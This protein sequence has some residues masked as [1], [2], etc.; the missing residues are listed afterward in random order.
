MRFNNICIIQKRKCAWKEILGIYIFEISD[1]LF[2]DHAIGSWVR[3]PHQGSSSCIFCTVLHIAGSRWRYLLYGLSVI[4]SQNY[5]QYYSAMGTIYRLQKRLLCSFIY[6]R[7]NWPR[8][9]DIQWKWLLITTSENCETK[10]I[11]QHDELHRRTG[12]RGHERLR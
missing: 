7:K 12:L 11:L 9:G 10:K 1:I 4:R 5:L 2:R 8:S 3:L 6:K